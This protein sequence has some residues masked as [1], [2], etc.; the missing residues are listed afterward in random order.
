MLPGVKLYVDISRLGTLP[1]NLKDIKKKVEGYHRE[2]EERIHQ[3]CASR[4]GPQLDTARMR[5]I[6][7]D[8]EQIE[9]GLDT[10]QKTLD[11]IVKCYAACEK[12]ARERGAIGNLD[13]G[14]PQS[15][16]VLKSA[17]DVYGK[18]LDQGESFA[19]GFW[20]EIVS[21]GSRITEGF[22]TIFT[23]LFYCIPGSDNLSKLF[24]LDS[25]AIQKWADGNTEAYKAGLTML[26]EHPILVFTA[27]LEEWKKTYE[28]KGPA[29]IAGRLGCDS[30][31]AILESATTAKIAGEARNMAKKINPVVDAGKTRSSVERKTEDVANLAKQAEKSSKISRETTDAVKHVMKPETPVDSSNIQKDFKTYAGKVKDVENERCSASVQTIINKFS[32]DKQTGKRFNYTMKNGRIHIENGIQT[33]DFVIDMK[34]NLHIGRGHSYLASGSSVQAAGTMQVNSQ[35]YIRLIT[36]ESGHFQPTTIQAMNYP[37]V[38]RNIGLNVNNTWIKIGE[39]KTSMS[40]YV[41][42]SKVVYNGP[43]KNMP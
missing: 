31:I 2:Y 30:F 23:K 14:I 24:G 6:Q 5:E 20:D 15:E 33:V 42:D 11:E 16:R 39:F 37:T 9:R 26:I 34:G 10:L 38:F 1:D 4:Y 29:Y 43:I 28:E 27:M 8:L 3:L 40:N 7:D 36:N 25:A 22:G 19:K 13:K 18:I 41:I 12:R 35:G 32:N 17:V 21:Q